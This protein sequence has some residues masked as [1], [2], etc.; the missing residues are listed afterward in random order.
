MLNDEQNGF[1][2]NRS[3]QDQLQTF[4]S[5]IETR[6]INGLHTF[7]TF[8]D[9]SKAYDMIPRA[10]LW[11]KLAKIG[12]RG[13]IMS[14]IQSL[15][16]NVQCSV[17]INNCITSNFGVSNGLKQ[18]CLMSPMLFN[19]YIN[20]L[21]TEIN[22]LDKGLNINGRKVSMLLYADDI[23]LMANVARDLQCMLNVLN[24]WCIRWGLSVNP[25]KTKVVHFRPK[26][27]KKC[28][29]AFHCGDNDLEIVNKYKY[30]GLWFTDNIDLKYMAEQ[31]AISAH[32]ALGIVIAKSKAFG[33]LPYDCFSKL[34][35]SLVQSVLDYGACVWGLQEFECINAVQHRATRFFLGVGKKTPNTAIMGEMGWTPQMVAQ[36]QCI[37][38][39]LCRYSKMDQGRLNRHV[40]KWALDKNCNNWLNKV[41]VMFESVQLGNLLDFD[42]EHSKCDINVLKERLMLNF[43]KS[44]EN[45]VNRI[46]AKKGGG[47]NKLRTYRLFKQ[48]YGV[49]DY[50]RNISIGI[51]ARKAF[52]QLRCGSAPINVEL[53]RYKNGIYLPHEERIC[54]ICLDGV[55]DEFH[56]IMK[57]H[58]YEDVRDDLFD[59]ASRVVPHF[60]DCDMDEKFV[61]LMTHV[62][63][64][65][66]TAKACSHILSRRKNFLVV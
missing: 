32:R 35:N 5:V 54:P 44:W 16:V 33:G 34:Y 17:R 28:H 62:D 21:V 63:L 43:V 49:E 23:V 27:R 46:D 6:R 19:L 22:L 4:M 53:G 51:R 55:E 9:F 24:Q 14:A 47:Q 36:I 45:D 2:K 3:C 38:R 7:T 11:Y 42:V 29:F 40:I 25:R 26:G 39:Q 31:V 59:S 18:G 10:H 20:D 65:K 8:V 50:V 30:L 56:V 13:N 48:E 60:N 15:Y 57:C 58:F 37:G 61:L 1:I 41:K 66:F 52:A 64:T 12:V